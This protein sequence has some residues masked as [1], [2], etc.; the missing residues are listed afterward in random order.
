MSDSE[1]ARPTTSA[2]RLIAPL[3]WA[4]RHGGKSYIAK[5]IVALM[6]PRSTWCHYV[7]PYAGGLAVLLA[8]DPAG[9]SEV[10]ND[11]NGSLYT[12]WRVLRDS[13]KFSRFERWCQAAPFSEQIFLECA[14]YLRQYV[15]RPDLETERAC[16]F[17]AT[18][19]MS[20]AGRM[21]AFAPISRT[22][23]RRGMN[24][25]ASA[26][27]T[28]VEGL[29]AVHDRLKRVVIVGPKPA[30]EVIRQQDGP[31]TLFYIDAPYVCATR[32]APDVYAHEMTD[33][34]HRE[35]VATLV[36]CKGKCMVSMYHHPIYDSLSLDHGWR[37][38]EF[39]IA[40]H[41]AGGATKKRMTEC[42]W[43]NFQAPGA[44]A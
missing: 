39:D 4:D 20:L 8:N 19:R 42:L 2:A 26:W 27:L 18:C 40:N 16:A 24:E 10:V 36:A 17:F 31:E 3:K 21:K 34:E 41:A 6:P 13:D 7:E 23:T 35:L 14:G 32:T 37:V 22:R 9:I 30:C 11:L 38:V 44:T 33:D 15:D 43:M 28:C 25:Q 29:P 12:F 5:R 1:K